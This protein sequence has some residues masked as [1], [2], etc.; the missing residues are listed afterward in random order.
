[1]LALAQPADAKI[2][3]TPAHRKITFPS[4]FHLDL[5]HDRITDFDLINNSRSS[6]KDFNMYLNVVPKSGQILGKKFLYA[7]ALPAGVKVGSSKTFSRSNQI[8]ASWYIH[9]STNTY[10]G[11]RGQWAKSGKGVRNRYLGLDFNIEGKK[12]FGWA[13]LSVTVT[14][15]RRPEFTAILTGYA[16]ETIPN[17][18]IITG[19]TTAPEDG[20][21]EAPN[22]SVTAPTPDPA[23][24][25]MLALGAPALSIWRRENSVGATH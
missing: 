13:R 17:K 7:S 14:K 10:I 1:M 8:M 24:L 15:G 11:Y 19:R 12:H 2:V 21:F 4:T 5:N 18:P 9:I 16:Y 3:Y 25:G 22:A 20:A 6:G 23:T